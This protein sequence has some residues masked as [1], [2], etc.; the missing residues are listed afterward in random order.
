MR[1][2]DFARNDDGSSTS[3]GSH[4]LT[5]NVGNE[6][7]RI[8]EAHSNGTHHL[9]DGSNYYEIACA[10]VKKRRVEQGIWNDK[11]NEVA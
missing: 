9:P 2:S 10:D 11:W 5:A 3:A 1:S 4:L 8:L 6:K 7:N